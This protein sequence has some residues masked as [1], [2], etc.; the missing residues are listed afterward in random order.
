MHCN[1]ICCLSDVIIKTFSQSPSRIVSYRIFSNR[2]RCDTIRCGILTCAQHLT[3]SQLNLAHWTA[4]LS[5]RTERQ[6]NILGKKPNQTIRYYVHRPHHLPRLNVGH[7]FSRDYARDHTPLSA[8]RTDE[9]VE[10]PFGLGV[11][12][13][14]T[15]L[16]TSTMTAADI[17]A[18]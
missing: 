9:A 7:C 2:I 8:G 18:T 3:S 17:G 4:S 1:F 15:T 14:E 10:M 6:R 11:C 13:L 16:A 5:L 12:A